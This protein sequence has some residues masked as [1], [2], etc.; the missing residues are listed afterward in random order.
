MKIGLYHLVSN[1]HDEAYI[2]K[3]LHHF[4]KEIEGKLGFK[5]ID[6]DL[7]DFKDKD[8]FPLIFVKSGGVEGKFKKSSSTLMAIIGY[9]PVT[10]T[11]HYLPHWRLQHF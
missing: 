8:Y 1:I 2:D 6:I 7:K 10:Y 9:W 11:T 4:K 3:S 5:F